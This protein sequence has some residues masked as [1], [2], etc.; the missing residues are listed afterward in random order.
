MCTRS[1]Q[2]ISLWSRAWCVHKRDIHWAEHLV[3]V[4]PTWWG[5]FP[6]AAQGFPGP[7][8]HAGLRLPACHARPVGQAAGLAAPPTW[9]RRWTRHH[10]S[11]GSST[12]RR[13]SRRWREQ[14]S[15]IAA[16]VSRGSRPSGPSLPPKLC[17]REKWS[18]TCQGHRLASGTRRAVVDAATHAPAL[19]WLAAL[20]LQFYPMTWIAYTVGALLAAQVRHLGNAR[21]T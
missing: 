9:S 11:I 6:G 21:R 19:A 3:F 5:T 15:A 1:R 14:R 16:S 18:G 12:A 10:S 17:Q 2:N 13:E 4:Y 20:R 8:S 7:G